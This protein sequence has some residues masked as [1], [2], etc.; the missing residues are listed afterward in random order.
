MNKALFK[1]L[2]GV[3]KI[4]SVILRDSKY[5]GNGDFIDTGFPL[6]NLAF[7]GELNGGF[8]KGL[9]FFAGPSKHFKSAYL[10]IC[11][12]A[13]QRKYPDGFVI[14]YD[15]EFGSKESYF[16]SFGV[17]IDRVVHKPF[18]NIEELKFDL[19]PTLDTITIDD[20]VMFA[21][22]SFGQ[23][24]SKK[25]WEDAM[26]A[27][28][29]ADMTRA[30]ALKS[31][32]RMITPY[33]AMNNIPAVGVNHTYDTQEK[34]STKVMSGGTG[35]QYAADTVLF[36]GKRANK[37]ADKDIVGFDFELTSHKSRFVREN[38]KF[39]ITVSYEGGVHKYSGIFDLAVE[40][41]FITQLGAWYKV[42]GTDKNVR[43]KD[44]E[45]NVE[46]MEELL[47]NKEFTEKV[48]M[49][50]KLPIAGDDSTSFEDFSDTGEVSIEDLL[51]SE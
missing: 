32:S 25:E 10:C 7:S 4:E 31:L 13:Y 14:F 41:N 24:A 28:E 49:K 21:F 26:T 6:L 45:N 33:L 48:E 37:G 17:D 30:K 19:I 38:S 36:V 22:D 18:K 1:K 29:A 3:G 16:D 20:N 9:S 47:N 35:L 5:F 8:S 42:S 27:N 43:R 44:L 50:Y 15:N 51:D 34:Y 12:A 11:M 39:P 46:F 23:A 40:M 2:A